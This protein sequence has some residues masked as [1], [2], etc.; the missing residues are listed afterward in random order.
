M[1]KTRSKVSHGATQRSIGFRTSWFVSKNPFLFS[2]VSYVPF[3]RRMISAF[4]SS[5]SYVSQA[6]TRLM[7]VV[8]SLLTLCCLCSIGRLSRHNQG[9]LFLILVRTIDS[10]RTKHNRKNTK[11]YYNFVDALRL[12]SFSAALCLIS[13]NSVLRN[14][15][16][17]GFFILTS[18]KSTTTR[19]P[20]V[21][22]PGRAP[23]PH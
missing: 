5:L 22:F 16:V 21:S 17:T 15:L 1:W 4:V 6:P 12:V 7:S 3:S 11:W 18:Y 8:L 2:I 20:K 13:P 23:P 9:S 19:M 10:E 14:N